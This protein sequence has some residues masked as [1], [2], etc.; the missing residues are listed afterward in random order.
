MNKNDDVI[1]KLK[2]QIEKQRANI[3]PLGKFSPTTNC[4]LELDGQ[5]YNLN[6]L[7]KDNL[8]VLLV[9]L[10]AYCQAAKE[11]SL[12]ESYNL[13]GYNVTDWIS[14]LRSKLAIIQVKAE[15]DKLNKMENRLS[16][17]LSDDKKIELELNEILKSIS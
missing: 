16:V 8:I 15:Q 7:D 17:L 9:R 2:E 3:K 6:T 4:N 11:L 12:T 1:L 14:D 5:R 10:S 13:S